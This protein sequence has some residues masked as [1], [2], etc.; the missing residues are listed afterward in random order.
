[1]DKEIA[2]FLLRVGD[3]EAHTLPQH[4]AGVAD[5]AAGLRIERRLV[6]N[7]RAA[8][9]VL[10][11]ID[12]RAVLDQRADHAFSGFSLVAEEFGGAELLAQG[13]PDRFARGIARPH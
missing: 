1:M 2:G 9:A 4:H 7:D 6:E 3:A 13:K 12:G 5:L 11:L 8:L 10:E